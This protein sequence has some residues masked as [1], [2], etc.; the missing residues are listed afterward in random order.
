MSITEALAHARIEFRRFRIINPRLERIAEE[1]D[2]LRL[3]GRGSRDRWERNG[4]KGPRIAQKFLPVIGPSGTGKSTCIKAYIESLIANGD[5]GDEIRPVVHVSLSSQA[6]TKRLGSDILDEYEDPEFEQ[7]TAGSLLRRASNAFDM[8][9]TEVVVLD[10]IHHLIHNDSGGKTAWSVAETIKN[11]LNRGGAPLILIGTEE[12]K[13]ILVNNRQLVNRSYDPIFLKPL[14]ISVPEQNTMFQE[15]CGG[16][17]LKL[18][19]HGIFDRI[20]GLVAGDLPACIYDVSQG[21]I[22]VASNVFEVATEIAIR[23]GAACISRDDVANAIDSWAI[24]LGVTDYNP[25]R[26]GPR[27]LQCRKVAA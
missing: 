13:P 8:A 4:C 12:A 11:M 14:D 23:R 17:D 24:P 21:L 22:G 15:H 6:T 10:E 27:D 3:V 19:E 7:G 16:F 9:R 5:L 20:S 2:V 18:V 26:H 25:I 1:I